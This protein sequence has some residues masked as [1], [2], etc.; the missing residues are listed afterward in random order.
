MKFLFFDLETTGL[1]C[2]ENGIHQISGCVEVDGEVKENFNYSVAPN[3]TLKISDE[4]L[5]IS[6]KTREEVQAYPPMNQVYKQF[7]DL[8]GKYV[9]KYD[10]K[11]KFFLIGYN[12]SSFDN[13]FLRNWFIQN[14]DKYF[15]SWF[16]PNT[17]DVYVLATQKLLHERNDMQDFKL[18]TVCKKLGI[19]VDELKLHDANYDIELTRKLYKIVISLN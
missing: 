4:A 12:N 10:K 6:N 3:P 14:N 5:A 1:S 19:E 18:K 16:W 11:D 15:G 2:N 7:I 8:L 17:L 9:D 13:Q